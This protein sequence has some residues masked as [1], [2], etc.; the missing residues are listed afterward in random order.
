MFTAVMSVGHR[1]CGA[2]F[3]AYGLP[4]PYDGASISAAVAGPLA[5]LAQNA[6]F[7][8]E[9]HESLVFRGQLFFYDG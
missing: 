1:I 6:A 2:A 7:T 9:D 8:L 3:F 5:P 4:P